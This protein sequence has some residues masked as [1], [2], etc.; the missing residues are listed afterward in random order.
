MSTVSGIISTE[1]SYSQ[2]I[3]NWDLTGNSKTNKQKEITAAGLPLFD[4][5]EETKKQIMLSLAMISNSINTKEAGSGKGLLLWHRPLTTACTAISAEEDKGLGTRSCFPLWHNCSC[6]TS[7]A[8][9]AFWSELPGYGIT[10]YLTFYFWPS[11]INNFIAAPLCYIWLLSWIH[12]CTHLHSHKAS[13]AVAVFSK[14]FASW[15]H[16][17][18]TN[19]STEQ[20][21][22]LYLWISFQS[23]MVL[24]EQSLH[25]RAVNALLNF[26]GSH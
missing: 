21:R 4:D 20:T 17:W 13:E 18:K 15:I 14:R 3:F 22:V 6:P 8:L 16:G 9:A 11:G 2:G 10:V 19:T 25:H 7:S 23:S 1:A 5:K 24:R 26:S 12:F